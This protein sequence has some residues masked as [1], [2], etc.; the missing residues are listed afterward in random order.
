MLASAPPAS[1][2]FPYPLS[3][4]SERELC[5]L[6]EY[7]RPVQF[8]A[9]ACIFEQDSPGDTCYIVDEGV[10]RIELDRKGVAGSEMDSDRVLGYV[11]PGTILGELTLL[12]GQPRSAS[13]FAQTPVLARS[14]SAAEIREMGRIN[15]VVTAALYAALGRSAA[16]KLRQTN[17]RLA[18]AIFE[19]SRDPE[20]DEMV[21]RA[22]EAQRE[23]QRWPEDRIDALLLDLARAVADRAQELALATVQETGVGDVRSKTIKN[24]IGSLGIYQSLVG[25]PGQGLISHDEQ[26]RVKDLASPVGVVFGLVPVT[27]PVAVLIFKV[28]IAVKGR[29]ALILSPHRDAIKVASQVEDLL[30][31]VLRVHGAPEQLIQCVRARTSRK[32]TAQ[33]MSHP[34]VSLVLAT[35]GASMV[36]AA[37]SAGKPAIGVGPGNT[38]TLICSDVDATATVGAILESKTFDHGLLCGSEHNLVVVASV[39]QAVVEEFE[40]Q[41]AAVLSSEEAATFTAHAVDRATGHLQPAVI[42]QPAAGTAEKAGITRDYP[43]RLI[44]V[45]SDD[46][47]PGNAYA[48]EK[49][50]PILSLFTVAD[51]DDGIDACRRLLA[52]DGSG[53]TASIHT[54][55]EAVVE[56][57]AAEM[58]VGR[59]LVNTPA[60]Q[61][62]VGATTGLIPSLT[63]GC[64]TFGGNSTTDNVTYTHLLNIKRLAHY[65]PEIA[66]N[67]G[68]IL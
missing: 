68:K 62:I 54:F 52:V 27:S 14:I 56:R 22:V 9:G 21:K 32:K 18:L 59:I 8:A 6:N 3:S 60:T 36:K 19:E 16:M 41:G 67:I 49:M 43:I 26:R 38:P 25:L 47:A 11:E 12:D 46:I 48:R 7:V 34:D 44:V 5:V 10:I 23:V 20:V 57:F 28:L 63:L 33:F 37:Y 2:Q 4:L 15:P 65:S 64:G 1:R 39:R 31:E 13:A 17:E 53:H 61:G 50:A 29:N 58:P 51:E 30:K 66:A 55:Q 40:R 24:R 42:G 35:G 45:P